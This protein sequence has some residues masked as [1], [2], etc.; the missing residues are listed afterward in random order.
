[1]TAEFVRAIGR[2]AL[3]AAVINSVIGV[4]IFGL[5][6]PIAGLVGAGSPVAV[7]AAGAS[8][9][10]IVLCF[11]EVG[12]RF[13][14]AG[15]PYL[16]V[17]EALGPAL[18]FQVGWLHIWTRLLS[19]AAVLN[20]LTS[21]L[22]RLLPWVGTSAGRAT[23][24]TIAVV[25]VTLVN[26]AGVRQA[27]WTVNAFTVAKLAPLIGLVAVGVFYIDGSIIA[28]QQVAR[29][30]W[31][32]AILLLVFA[33]G[34]F[35][36]GIVAGGETKDPARDTSFALLVA[37]AA[38][39]V[40]YSLI[41]W[42]VVGV[43]PHASEHA[44]PITAA[45]ERLIGPAGVP[46]GTIAVVISVYG[47]LT[48]FAMMTPRIIFAMAAHGELPRALARLHPRTRVPAVAIVANAAIALALGLIS[49]FGQ[50]ATFAAIARLGIYAATCA[51]LI[52]LR[53]SRGPSTA[54]RAPAGPLL[55]ILG[56]AFCAW[57]LTT[58]PIADAW[59]LPLTVLAGVA[60]WAATR[61]ARE[62]A[63]A[64]A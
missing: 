17:R 50:L 34:G 6:A 24:I 59:F 40:L 60:V 43:L 22:E 64:S 56:M 31:T 49:D 26:T 9:V 58:R 21:Y 46:F 53:T 12:S 11:A 3:T 8:I 19:A 52:V 30:Q 51:A 15:G 36:S 13:D 1:M 29:A 27:S 35:E 16:Y 20:V 41:Q 18:G 5:P 2:W 28:T 33:F 54:F 62:V 44:A 63:A 10:V 45:L 55:S 38:I 37:L 48:G 23:A 39:T 25:L 57:L 32:D 61:R 47:W 42:T 14:A 7:L 4:G